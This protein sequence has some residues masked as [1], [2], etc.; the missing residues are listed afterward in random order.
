MRFLGFL[1]LPAVLVLAVP[2]VASE[3][4]VTDRPD[5]TES[6]V[7][8]PVGRLQLEFGATVAKDDEGVEAIAV[9]EALLRWGAAQQL[10]VRLKL[11]SWD[12]E[13]SGPWRAQ[14]FGDVEA[15]VK[16][17]LHA[18]SGGSGVAG[19]DWALILATSA[20][21]GGDEVSAGVWQ[22]SAILAAGW[23]LG[24]D[25]SL[26]A[27]LGLSRP[28]GEGRRFTSAWLSS[29]VGVGIGDAMAV[30]VEL[31]AVQRERPGGPGT[32]T[33]QT[34]LT[35][36]FGADVQLDVRLARRLTSEGSD[37]LAGVGAG[38]RF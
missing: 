32:L 14:G 11:P 31:V 9:G 28:S 36:R 3:P 27:N 22:P 37:L 15:G 4:L 21:T 13:S 20:P 12:R 5:F 7:V 1:P 19:A 33:L 23:E 16:V 38:V 29:A 8:V 17:H 10:E 18:A 30:F 24:G 6:A 2:A 26:G 34:G 35:R 25:W